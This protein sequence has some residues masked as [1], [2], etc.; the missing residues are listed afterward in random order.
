MT[1]DARVGWKNVRFIFQKT[2][3]TTQAS[4]PFSGNA[5]IMLESL[6]LLQDKANLNIFMQ[7]DTDD[8]LNVIDS[9]VDKLLYKQKQFHKAQL[10]RDSIPNNLITYIIANP[11]PKETHGL[12]W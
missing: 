7:N 4:K 2:T 1:E 12:T 11:T 3:I 6:N 5:E 8:Q 9:K 10:E